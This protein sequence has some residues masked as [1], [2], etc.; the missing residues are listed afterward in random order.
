MLFRAFVVAGLVVAASQ[1]HAEEAPA[2]KIA[3][4]VSKVDFARE[5]SAIL[6][7]HCVGCH[8]PATAEGG[9]NLTEH[10]KATLALESGARG[11]VPGKPEA[12]ELVRRITSHDADERMPPAKDHKPL[13]PAEIE[14]LKLWIAQGAQYDMHWSFRPLTRP[15][16]PQVKYP[17]AMRNP[18]DAFVLSKLDARGITPSPEADPYTLIKRL[19]FDLMGL[20][21]PVEEADEFA[22]LYRAADQLADPAAR[23]REKER[24]YRALVD[25]LLASPHFGERWGRH[26]LDMARYAD[27]DG[28]EKDRP[29]PDAYVYRDWVIQAFNAD[30]PFDQFT[31]EQLA[32]DLLPD[33]G[34][35]Q[36][37]ATAFNRQ[38][39]TNEEGGVDQEEFR[40]NA[41]FD[42]T[43][44]VGSV[45]L[46]LTVGCAKCHNHKYDPISQ[47]EYYQLFAFFN[48]ADEVSVKLPVG[49][50]DPIA[51]AKRLSPLEDALDARRRELFPEEQKWEAAERA[52]L[53]ST[54]N[55][56][57][58]VEEIE[59]LSLTAQSGAKFAKQKDG[60]YL[61]ESAQSEKDKSGEIDTYS[62]VLQSSLPEITGFRLEALADSSLP[63][64]G[65]GRSSSGNFVITRLSAAIVDE[66]GKKL[67]PLDLQRATAD[68]EQQNFKAADVLAATA[69]LKKGWAVSPKVDANHHL[70][71]RT[72]IPLKL[73]PHERVELTIEQLYGT[74][75]TLGR[76]R[77]RALT[78]DANEL[79][80]PAEVVTALKQYPEKRI[81]VTQQTLFDYYVGQD[82][83]V[84]ELQAKIEAAHREFKVTVMPVRTIA[85]ARKNR[86][87]HR[88]D[89]GD[90]LSP[91]EE[92]Q[93]NGP[94]ILPTLASAGQGRN[95][96]DLSRWLVSPQNPLTPR[97]VANQFWSRLFGAGLVRTT[98]DFGLRGDMPSHPEL[99]DWLAVEFREGALD[100]QPSRPWSIKAFLKT[101]VTS[102]TYRQASTHRPELFE[103]DPQNTLLYRQNRLRVEGE[104]VRDLALGASGL[105]ATKIGGPSVFPPMPADLAKLSY[106]NSFSW[107]DSVGENR[108]R[109]GMYTFFKR[110]IPHPTLMTFDC[111]DANVSCINRTVSNTPLQALTLLNNETFAETAQA[112]AKR[113]VSQSGPS[114]EERLADC[115]RTCLVRPAKSDE[116]DRLSNLLDKAREHYK[117][118][119]E[120]AEKLIGRHTVAAVPNRETAAWTATLRVL[121]NLDEFIT[122]E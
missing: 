101:L 24:L 48:G 43:D 122:R 61:Y 26:W 62:L 109:R 116:I 99:L 10:S 37:I 16:V 70:Q 34:P 77:I 68:F 107:T 27:S 32:G 67:R 111:P 74:R 55:I 88:F 14:T 63:K 4:A 51:L 94:A 9:F 115:I 39:L 113:L 45:W 28:Y 49:A 97:V 89:R 25:K 18:L 87:T 119:P 22:R 103:L 65:A 11:I 114:D 86:K 83:Q 91:Q 104:V 64:K 40:V 19:H 30:M 81:A 31:V 29:R 98:G 96:L 42:R 71:V 58:K 84:K 2:A 79:N 20:L 118:D 93:P 69:N 112:M 102:A 90:F 78:G 108:Y 92:V 60:S 100:A 117:N 82:P 50:T 3:P 75:H 1:A 47:Q 85:T 73:A 105:L 56:P 76:F 21:P 17:A 52:R 59:V 120:G 41:V 57:I 106:A 44:T 53:E 46:G 95:R 54:P 7:E 23:A 36:R 121:L 8:G 110:T 5:V 6:A 72:K 38:T 35:N 80:L 33:A 12:S 66:A 15:A 13:K